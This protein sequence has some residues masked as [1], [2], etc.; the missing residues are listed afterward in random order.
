MVTAFIDDHRKEF[1]VEPI[2]RVLS[3][4][5]AKIA[6]STYYAARDRPPSARA[7]RDELVLV[8]IR[9]VLVWCT[10]T[11]DIRRRVPHG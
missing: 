3:A 11:M 8:E 7:C 5:G 1:G 2:C 4:H 10:S 6:P 9:R